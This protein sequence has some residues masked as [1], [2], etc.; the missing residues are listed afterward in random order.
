MTDA[1]Q[2][3][4][5]LVAAVADHAVS[6]R[7]SI[8]RHPE[9]GNHEFRTTEAVF[10]FLEQAGLKPQR[11]PGATGLIVDIG[12]SGPIVAFR[13]DLD[14]LPVHEVATSAYASEVDGVMHACGH[15]AHTAIAAGIAVVLHRT[16]QLPG[17]ARFLFQPAE[18]I[19]PG[20]AIEMVRD[21]VLE[22]VRSILAFH[23]DPSLPPGTL[24]IRPDAITGASDRIRI[25]LTG[26]GGHTSRPHQTVDLVSAA[27][28]V[29][30][31]LPTRLQRTIDPRKPVVI[32]FG[33]IAG[34]SAEN[35]IPTRVDLGGTI[36]LFDLDLWR[37]LPGHVESLVHAIVEPLGATMKIE[38]E[39][40]SPPVI[41]DQDVIDTVRRTAAATL[42]DHAIRPTEQSLGSED[43]S[44]VLESVPGALIRLGAARPDRKVDLHA[45]DFDI[46]ERAITSGMLAG[47]A[48]LLGMMEHKAG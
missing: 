1:Q 2:T 31:D 48:A 32:V 25:S 26:P 46:D 6:L 23:V 13:A 18:E 42:G 9:L 47:S 24:G 40:G 45:A 37:R 29:V 38:Y 28:R 11:R 33:S 5:R 7:R 30:L 15:D 44:W 27:A 12:H 41:N 17:R 22:G 4:H 8:H 3:L 14:A 19:I 10:S 43:F 39:Q 35:V 16:E 20:G 34:G 36:R 21:G